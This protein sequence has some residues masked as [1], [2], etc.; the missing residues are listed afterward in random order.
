MS[1]A[2]LTQQLQ[3]RGI[4]NTYLSGLKPVDEGQRMVGYAHTL[5]YVPARED[6]TDLTRGQNAQRRAIESLTEDE[7]LIM[8]ARGEPDAGTIGDIFVMRSKLLGAAGVV[9]DGALRDTPAIR[10]LGLPVY[11]QSSHAA[12]L[13]RMHMP[14]D[15]QIPIACA[16]VTV[17]PGDIL[18]GDG[19]GVVV[20]PA[21]LAEEIAAASVTAGARGGVGPR[22]RRCRGEHARHVPDREGP[23]RRVRGLGRPARKLS[24][25]TAL[26]EGGHAMPRRSIEAT[27]VHHVNPIPTAS[28]VG[29]L[30]MS[31]IIPPRNPGAE[32]MPEEPEA[33]LA[34]LFHHVGEML[35]VGGAGWEHIVKMTFF[36]PDLKLRDA[37]NAP[38]VEHFPD[39]K[40]ATG[41]PHAARGR[42]RQVHQLRLRGVRRVT[43]DASGERTGGELVVEGLRRWGVDVVFGLPGVQLDG[44][45]E[46]FALEP[47]IRVDPHTP[48]AGDQLHGRRLP[49]RPGASVCAPSCRGLGVLNAAAGL[50][51]AYACGSRVL[52]IVGQVSTADLG[53]GRGVLHEIPDQQAMC[54]VSSDAPST[55][56]V[57]RTS[58]VSSTR[59]SPRSRATSVR[60]RTRS[61]WAGTPCSVVRR[62][63]GPASPTSPARSSPTSR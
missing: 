42:R 16:G 22:A 24:R 29:P 61:R 60:G 62:R 36:V 7:V 13:G 34:N 9:T 57:P 52:C 6:L 46:G 14:L 23:P 12:T 48:R 50:A 2:T 53:R 15:H 28:R 10:T 30:L 51:T 54:A 39:A 35:E 56:R 5:R 27:S 49:R 40:R 33:Q 8:E 17:I 25:R 58:P 31:S 4:R 20:L 63:P 37:I 44:M 55:R 47:S 38:W 18:V 26:T 21:A 19:E 11:H 32:D 59:C 43:V 41:P 45:Y 3:R 1:T